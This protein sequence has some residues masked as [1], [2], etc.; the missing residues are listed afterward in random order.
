MKIYLASPYSDT[1]T[2]VMELRFMQ[3]AEAGALILRASREVVPVNVFVPIAHSHPIAE[4]GTL[5]HCDHDLWLAQDQAFMD[6]ADVMIIVDLP[7]WNKSVGVAFEHGYMLASGKPIVHMKGLT[8]EDAKF[9]LRM[10]D[11]KL[12]SLR[13]K[14]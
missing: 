13:R 12:K 11:L 2:L 9:A 6:W 14:S 5:E 1:N 10:A 7:G 4:Y 3:A 8:F